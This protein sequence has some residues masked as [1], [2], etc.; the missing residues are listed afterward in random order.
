MTQAI[1]YQDDR[2][3]GYSGYLHFLNVVRAGIDRGERSFVVN[4]S[5]VP[6]FYPDGMAPLVATILALRNRGCEF[7]VESPDDK[8]LSGYW[9]TV[10]WSQALAGQGPPSPRS[11]SYLPLTWFRDY[12]EAN[13]LISASLNILARSAQFPAG[14]L[15]AFEWSLNELTD[16][17]LVH[18]RV[19]QGWM[20][21][22]NYPD[23]QKVELVVVDTGIG[24]LE[25]LREGY[26]DLASDQSA[27][28]LAVQKGATRN[29]EVGQG[30]GL[31]GVVKITVEANG[32]ANLHSGEGRVLIRSGELSEQRG[33]YHSGTLVSVTLPTHD[34]IDLS[35]ALWGHVPTPAFELGYL[36]EAG[37]EF[38]LVEEA[39]NFGNRQTGQSLRNKLANL[40]NMFP[41][42]AIA[43]DF[44]GVEI[45]SA[46]FADEFIAKLVADMGSVRFFGRVRLRNMNEF[47]SDTLDRVIEQRLGVSGGNST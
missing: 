19:D 2:S 14:V 42:E 26:S 5:D 25:S 45:V 31:S 32:W 13:D 9:A 20:Q 3:F 1:R 47:I 28:E 34:P 43:I 36:E 15:Q 27:V 10:G 7:D 44:D 8:D 22:T 40:M 46:S 4:L 16:N 6:F 11:G 38:R 12:E 41:G 35:R 29:R 18:A 37:I 33:P 39:T 23:A 30:N 24:I 21:L 17:V